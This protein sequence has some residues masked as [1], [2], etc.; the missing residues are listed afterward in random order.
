VNEKLLLLSEGQ[1]AKHAGVTLTTIR[2]HRQAGKIAPVQELHCAVGTIRLFDAEAVKAYFA[3]NK[4]VQEF[5][6][7]AQAARARR[8][9]CASIY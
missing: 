6:A 5:K 4:R 7:R 8:L 2:R 1:T 3:A 9:K